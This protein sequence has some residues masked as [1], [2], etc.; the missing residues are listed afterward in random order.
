[1]NR[2]IELII[3]K[4]TNIYYEENFKVFNGHHNIYLGSNIYLVDGIINAGDHEGKVVIEDFVF[5]GHG[6]KILTRG[7]DYNVFD[8]NRQLSVVE[9]PIHIKQG[10][11]ISSGSIILGGVTVGKNAVIGAGSVVTKDVPDH[12]MVAG[13][14]AKL[15]KYIEN[16][17]NLM[18]NTD[19]DDIDTII[20]KVKKTD[21]KIYEYGDFTKYND[22]AFIEEVY[23]KLL[24][25]EVDQH[26]L[27]LYLT[28]LRHAQKSKMEIISLIRASKEGREKNI[29]LLGFYK[30][31]FLTLLYTVPPFS[32]LVKNG[33]K[34]D[35]LEST[36][37]AHIK[38]STN[39]TRELKD[40]LEDK[41]ERLEDK[42]EKLEDKIDRVED[43]VEDKVDIEDNI[44]LY[45]KLIKE[46]ETI[47]LYLNRL[48]ALI[49]EAKKSMPPTI[50]LSKIEAL[51]QLK[52]HKFES[53]YTEF[54]DKFRGEKK[55]IKDKLSLYLPFL[56]T[57]TKDSPKANIL[58]IAC[59][60]GEWLELL[61]DNGYRAKGIDLNPNMVHI[62]QKEGLDVEQQE[63][64]NYLKSLPSNSLSLITGF[65]IIEHLHSFDEVLELL[66]ESHRVLD[67][68]GFMIYETPNPRNILVG[69]SDFYID[70]SHQTPLHPMTMKFFAQKLSFKNVS[71]LII[72]DTKLIDIDRIDFTKIEDYVSIG[73]DYALIGYKV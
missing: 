6:V 64:L 11:W 62:C 66:E 8:K 50:K 46:K 18:G 12:A 72:N 54:E 56:H 27:D 32:F 9:K 68:G 7:H 67:G 45:Q 47:K 28:K 60:R 1:M 3:N 14:P 43:K 49:N 13:N 59:G 33:R 51:S 61:R 15:L 63:A 22:K 23:R 44:G 37:Y 34:I 29:K 48:D 73:R 35:N 71:S 65:H 25:R 30:R 42:I 52:E 58:D 39:T 20:S 55:E 5:F 31:L 17:E 24:Q 16:G 53:L 36:L 38:H 57:V 40:K 19:Y 41:I 70:P 21:K 69:A 4:G 2:D 26:G 10:A